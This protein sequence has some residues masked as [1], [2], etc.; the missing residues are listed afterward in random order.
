MQ[1][2]ANTELQFEMAR[3]DQIIHNQ[4]EAQ[5]NLWNLLM[6]LGLDEKQILELAA[7]QGLTIEDSTMP[8]YLEQLD[9]KQVPNLECRKSTPYMCCPCTG[10]NYSRSSCSFQNHQDFGS[11]LSMRGHW[12]MALCREEH[13][14]SFYLLSHN[15]SPAYLRLRRSSEQWISG[16]PSSWFDSPNNHPRDLRKSFPEMKSQSSPCNEGCMSTSS[17]TADLGQQV[18]INAWKHS[19]IAHLHSS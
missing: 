8:P 9:Q 17:F 10:Q 19:N 7:K 3:R 15:H 16:R 18:K 2:M 14:S 1:G 12:D 11:R 5:R 4:R 13:H 6:G